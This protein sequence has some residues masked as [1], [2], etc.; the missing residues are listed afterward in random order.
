MAQAEVGARRMGL[1]ELLVLALAYESSLADFI[2]GDDDDMVELAPEARLSVATVRALLSGRA[3]R[4]ADLAAAAADVPARAE[5]TGSV[6]KGRF[7]DVLDQA[8]RFGIGEQQLQ[9]ALDGIG[10]AERYAAR[11]LGTTP[12]RINLAAMRRWGRTLAEERDQRVAE[13]G[14][15]AS[16]RQLQ[17]LRG[18]V[19]RELMA[20]LADEPGNLD[21]E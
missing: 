12:D 7:P 15:A 13:R 10:E 9:R 6:R 5:T 19:T 21:E 2:V 20:E 3:L 17:A 1:D 18:H 14:G 8:Q 16:P 11:K 4:L